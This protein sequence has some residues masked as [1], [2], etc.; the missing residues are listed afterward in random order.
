MKHIE[1]NANRKKRIVNRNKNPNKLINPY[2]DIN[3]SNSKN[4]NQYSTFSNVISNNSIKQ[5]NINI[6]NHINN[7]IIINNKFSQ[8]INSYLRSNSNN[9]YPAQ[10]MNLM[11]PH[12][13]TLNKKK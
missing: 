5:Q 8:P 2:T 11:N 3:K 7:N 4:N 1:N 12:P 13:Y 6:N 10:N 9:P